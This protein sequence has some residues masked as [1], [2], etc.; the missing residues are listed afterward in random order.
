MTLNGKYIGNVDIQLGLNAGPNANVNVTG[1]VHIT[2]NL[3][4]GVSG[5][6][7]RPIVVPDPSLGPA[8]GTV[9]VATG[10]ITIISSDIKASLTDPK[11]YLLFVSEK[12]SSIDGM[13]ITPNFA[14]SAIFFAPNGRIQVRSGSGGE[15][16]SVVGNEV[17]IATN[18][19]VTYGGATNL[20]PGSFCGL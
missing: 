9:I 4:I 16:G 15:T 1:P 20:Q 11:G 7:N 5:G 17:S 6:G 14:L 12:V 10:E 18:A 13:D 8:C 19:N 2:G 3:K